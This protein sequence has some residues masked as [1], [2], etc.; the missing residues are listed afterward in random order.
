MYKVYSD[1]G[2]KRWEEP[3][4]NISYLWHKEEKEINI[5][6]HCKPSKYHYENTPIQIYWKIYNQ[7]L[8]I[9]R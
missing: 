8:K 4:S 6:E 1:L 3:Q 9:F 2:E 5:M 7:K